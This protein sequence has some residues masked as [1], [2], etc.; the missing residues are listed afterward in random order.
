M[1][2]GWLGR[3]KRSESQ[4][5]VRKQPEG[6][7]PVPSPKLLPRGEIGDE[8]EGRETQGNGRR[9]G[10]RA[11]LEQHTPRRRGWGHHRP[12]RCSEVLPSWG[13]E[14]SPAPCMMGTAFSPCRSSALSSWGQ[15]QLAGLPAATLVWRSKPKPW[16]SRPGQSLCAPSAPNVTQAG[17]GRQ[18]HGQRSAKQKRMQKSPSLRRFVPLAQAGARRGVQ[19]GSLILGTRWPRWAPS[20][21]S[22]AR[23]PSWLGSPCCR[24]DGKATPRAAAPGA[25][26]P[27]D[28][29]SRPL[30]PQRG[31]V[32]DTIL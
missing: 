18:L 1:N 27:G 29:P 7:R 31:F 26:P 30:A 20:S 32:K 16:P 6:T 22:T 21:P 24:S 13:L 4:T 15:Q 5:R 3:C 14:P 12:M 11:E 23:A 19:G 25:T 10:N 28:A 2:P 17:F 9:T 8:A